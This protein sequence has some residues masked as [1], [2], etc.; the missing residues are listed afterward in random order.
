[1]T[2]ALLRGFGPAV[3]MVRVHQAE[4]N[5]LVS[6]NQLR[7]LPKLFWL[8]LKPRIG[9]MSSPNRKSPFF[10]ESLA[11]A[12]KQHDEIAFRIEVGI[13]RK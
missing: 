10:D 7:G 5:T 6:E 3:N 8:K 12:R 11:I 1:M 4:L 13:L 9:I 2:Q